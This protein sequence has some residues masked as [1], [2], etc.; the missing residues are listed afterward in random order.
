MHL[1]SSMY[2]WDLP[3]ISDSFKEGNA[4]DW[5]ILKFIQ[6]NKHKS[7]FTEKKKP[8]VNT[9]LT[10]FLKP[11]NSCKHLIILKIVEWLT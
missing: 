4:R 3:Y 6:T 1:K 7:K 9:N 5:Y 11:F 2:I 8:W 10:Y